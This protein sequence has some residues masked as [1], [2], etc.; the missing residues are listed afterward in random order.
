MEGVSAVP[1][2]GIALGIVAGTPDVDLDLGGTDTAAEA[3]KLVGSCSDF[4]GRAGV[5]DESFDHGIFWGLE[6]LDAGYTVVAANGPQQ[7]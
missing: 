1:G 5:E 3:E 2:I 6:S 4:A 7:I